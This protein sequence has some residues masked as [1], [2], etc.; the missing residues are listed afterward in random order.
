MKPEN[1]EFNKEVNVH[2]AAER[3]ANGQQVV[4]RFYDGEWYAASF[5]DKNSIHAKD[6][7]F[8]TL[9]MLPHIRYFVKGD[10]V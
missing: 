10:S 2:E 9:D 5:Q 6:M 4:L 3:Y 7:S 8:I 1:S